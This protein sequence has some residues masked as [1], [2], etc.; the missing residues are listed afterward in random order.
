[1][2]ARRIPTDRHFLLIIFPLQFQNEAVSR[3]KIG[4][5]PVENRILNVILL[6]N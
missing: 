3:V 6:N 1:M 5:M 4:E 2:T